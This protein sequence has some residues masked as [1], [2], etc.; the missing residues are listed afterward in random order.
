MTQRPTGGLWAEYKGRTTC[1]AGEVNTGKTS[2]LLAI[3]RAALAAGE[4][5]AVLDMAPDRVKNVGGK[6]TPP[7][8]PKVAYLTAAMAAPRLSGKTP[9]EVLGLARRNKDL[10]DGLFAR[11]LP[12]KGRALFVNDVSMYLQAGDVKDLLAFLNRFPSVVLN[13]YFGASLAGGELGQRER[14]EMEILFRACDRV[15][16]TG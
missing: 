12:P 14:N 13:G 16:L 7:D 2:R 3:L 11:A 4:A 1:L 10:L 15:I 8:S 5:A 6:M 9:A